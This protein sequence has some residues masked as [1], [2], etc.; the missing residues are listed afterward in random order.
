MNLDFLSMRYFMLILAI[1]QQ[2][3][4]FINKYQ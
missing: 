3:K 1:I 2:A 4:Y